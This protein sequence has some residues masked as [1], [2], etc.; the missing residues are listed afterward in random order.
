MDA[1]ASCREKYIPVWTLLQVAGGNIFQYGCSCKLQEEIYSD[2][3][4]GAGSRAS[5]HK[6]KGFKI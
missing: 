3:G 2:I 6:G 5:E 4:A 1:P